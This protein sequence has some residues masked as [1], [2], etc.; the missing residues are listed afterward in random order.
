[1]TVIADR[2]DLSV[3]G[4]LVP[5]LAFDQ[6]LIRSL[7]ASS[8][9]ELMQELAP[10]VTSGRGGA[11]AEPAYLVNGRR[12]ANFREIRGYPPEA[13]DRVEIYPEEVALRHGFRADQK[14]VNFVLRRE[15]RALE[16]E[17]E[18]GG[19]DEGAGEYVEGEIAR[20]H[21][22]GD[23]RFNLELEVEAQ[24]PIH[25]LDREVV[26]ATRDTP[27]SVRGNLSGRDGSEL[28]ATLS[29]LAGTVVTAAS[30]PERSADGPLVLQDL[31]PTA[32][33]PVLTDQRAWRTLA[34][35]VHDL[36]LV[37]SAAH[38][39]GSQLTMSMT[40]TWEHGRRIVELGIPGYTLDVDPANP[41]SPFGNAITVGRLDPARGVLERRD[42]TDRGALDIT[43]TGGWGSMEWSWLTELEHSRRETDIDRGL[44]ASAVDPG[45][46]PFG[47]HPLPLPA[48]TD[49]RSATSTRVVSEILASGPVDAFAAGPAQVSAALRYSHV[50]LD[51]RSLD[52]G[53]RRATQSE[54]NLSEF[55][56]NVDL[57]LAASRSL[58]RLGANLNLE[59]AELSDFGTLT[60]W[61]AGFTWRPSN[62]WR[63]IVSWASEE[64]APSVEELGDPIVATPNQRVFDFALGEA[65]TITRLEGGNPA[66]SAARR[67]VWRSGL[68]IEPFDAHDLTLNIDY[69]GSRVESP[70]IGFPTPSEEI[71]A[72]FGERFERDAEGVLVLLDARPLNVLEAREQRL[73][74]GLRYTR[75]I[76]ASGGRR[77]GR[78]DDDRDGRFALS[79]QHGWQLD[80][81][82]TLAPEIASIDYVGRSTG[83]R[84][85]SGAE[86]EVSLRASFSLGG[87]GGRAR[88]R[89]R[90][91]TS[92][93]PDRSG[94]GQLQTSDLATLD[95]KLFYTI[96]PQSPWGLRL[97]WLA[98][99][100]L[101]IGADNLFGKRAITRDT[102]GAIP[103]G[104]SPSEIDPLGR[105][106]YAEFRRLIR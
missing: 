37:A 65:V 89:W 8:V 75:P 104:S 82:L 2:L 55:R 73:D 10:E 7:G 21:L 99:A 50:S 58:G 45:A 64:T 13:I 32:N 63:V 71:E 105:V 88:L 38:P 27:A 66:L 23:R 77:T 22:Q 98:D 35:E 26:V 56:G 106:L 87:A 30:L 11:R 19:P 57:P 94:A 84:L 4:G 48:L 36:E 24:R 79:L 54:R 1:M 91:A 83:G 59:L 25:E 46:D 3:S 40:G 51:T 78:R 80:D 76:G 29:A 15:F 85:T 74:W 20:L 14:V 67:S 16:V 53:T 69:S 95:L 101:S 49:Q 93:L 44:D 70:I 43:L 18:A 47:A 42:E 17:A 41:F 5:E 62:A 96:A 12:I 9:E 103:A 52:A 86:H 90:D 68:R 72:A 92:S 28:D 100:R 33:N 97:P 34:P 31:L 39:F 60:S 6:A 61:G 102:T 81:T